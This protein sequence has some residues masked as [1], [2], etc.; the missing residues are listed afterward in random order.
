VPRRSAEKARV[1]G[2]SPPGK[3]P[4]IEEETLKTAQKEGTRGSVGWTPKEQ[5][6]FDYI[7]AKFLD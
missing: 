5:S 7:N 6:G 3:I 4:L 1:I 2:D